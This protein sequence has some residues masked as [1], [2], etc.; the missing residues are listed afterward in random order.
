MMK[1]LGLGQEPFVSGADS[2]IDR[3]VENIPN[4]E[5]GF[6]LLFSAQPFPNYQIKFE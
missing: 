1:K 2:I 5:S 4:A 6:S 3:M